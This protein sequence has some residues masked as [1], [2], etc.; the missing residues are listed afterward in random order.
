MH[1]LKSNTK[2]FCSCLIL[3]IS[4]YNYG[5]QQQ[6]YKETFQKSQ[7]IDANDFRENAEFFLMAYNGDSLSGQ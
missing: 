7:V 1:D 5:E 4:V 6:T 3:L 2:G